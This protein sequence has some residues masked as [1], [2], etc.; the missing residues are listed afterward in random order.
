MRA[1]VLAR[2]LRG[3]PCPTFR[4][5][6]LCDECQPRCGAKPFEPRPVGTVPECVSPRRHTLDEDSPADE[7]VSRAGDPRLRRGGSSTKRRWHDHRPASQTGQ[8]IA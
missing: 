7:N 3:E 8:G 1:T 5:R 2:K 4:R 6:G